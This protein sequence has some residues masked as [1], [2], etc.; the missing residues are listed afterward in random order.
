MSAW[1]AIL[2]I[3]GAGS[4]GGLINAFLASE[5]FVLS[6]MEQ[7]ADG[8]S[9]WRPGFI[10]NMLVGAVTALV[11][12]GLYSPIGSIALGSG[13]STASV[14]L[15]IRELAGAMLSGVGGAR[16]LTSEVDRR[17]EETARRS[18][19]DTVQNMLAA[20]PPPTRRQGNGS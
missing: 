2:L 4:V 13:Q 5:G 7:L 8:R 6:R 9:I 18:L 12:A 10:G 20:A 15:T 14:I 17:Y 3:A 11:L 19:N 1:L 16:L